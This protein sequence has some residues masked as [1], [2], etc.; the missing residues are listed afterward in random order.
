V[1]IFLQSVDFYT[2]DNR[3]SPD[4]RAR[5][6]PDHPGACIEREIAENGESA[7]VATVEQQ[8]RALDADGKVAAIR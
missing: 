8:I 1:C 2:A 6:R 7:R 3:H 4:R 5:Q